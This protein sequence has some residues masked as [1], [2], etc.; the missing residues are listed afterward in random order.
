MMDNT[1]APPVVL[2]TNIT[3]V[4]AP[5]YPGPP[6]VPV[7]ATNTAQV[8]HSVQIV[9]PPPIQV[10]QPVQPTVVHTTQVTAVQTMPTTVPGQVQCPR[11]HN[12]VVS[13]V[14]YKSGA[15]AW[16]ICAILGLFICW[17]CCWIPFVVDDC[18]DIYHQCPVCHSTMN[19]H[20][21]L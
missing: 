4:P 17:P 13:Q 8:Q 15:L 7:M 14:E 1:K 20:K 21:R 5:P 6:P 19:I 11:C 12:V 18:K 9:Q 16:L 3:S 2:Q 10:V